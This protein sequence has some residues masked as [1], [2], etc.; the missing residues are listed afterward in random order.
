[1]VWFEEGNMIVVVFYGC[2]SRGWVLDGNISC[3]C[4]RH[5]LEQLCLHRLRSGIE[6]RLVVEHPTFG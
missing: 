1:M 5:A 2:C 3:V 4:K 6:L